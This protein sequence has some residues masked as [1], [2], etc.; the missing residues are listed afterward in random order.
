M[1]EVR[2][3]I[4]DE[5][6]SQIQ[7]KIGPDVKATDIAKDAIALYNWAVGERYKGKLVLSSQPSGDDVTQLTMPNLERAGANSSVKP[8]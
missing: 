7:Q 1:A 4:P 6:I 8:L 5:I 2:L 3:Q